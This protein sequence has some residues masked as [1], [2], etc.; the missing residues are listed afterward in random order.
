MG[1]PSAPVLTC[2]GKEKGGK[3]VG[4]L[5]TGNALPSGLVEHALSFFC[6]IFLPMGTNT[7]SYVF[8]KMATA[9]A[10][11]ERI[12]LF[13]GSSFTSDVHVLDD[14]HVLHVYA[15]DVHDHALGLKAH[16]FLGLIRGTGASM[17]FAA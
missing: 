3:W 14:A 2:S 9:E 11:T 1:V 15:L 7:H 6:V 4:W 16:D 17:S 10:F 12:S 13:I 5:A 8:G